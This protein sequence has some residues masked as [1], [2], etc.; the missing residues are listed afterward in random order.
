MIGAAIGDW[1]DQLGRRRLPLLDTR[2]ATAARQ[3]HRKPWVSWPKG[4]KSDSDPSLESVMEIGW[5][6]AGWRAPAYAATTPGPNLRYPHPKQGEICENSYGTCP[7]QQHFAAL[8]PCDFRRALGRADAS[9]RRHREPRRVPAADR[10]SE[11]FRPSATLLP[12]DGRAGRTRRCASPGRAPRHAWRVSWDARAWGADRGPPEDRLDTRG[13][14]R[15]TG[16]T[17]V[18]RFGCRATTYR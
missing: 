7:G 14:P 11:G 3:R 9:G 13:P 6:R 1:D 8:M 10:A 15:F 5:A 4:R 12:G 17:G 16:S 2:R 18:V